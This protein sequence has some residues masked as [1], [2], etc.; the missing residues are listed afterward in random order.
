MEER[1]GVAVE[2]FR[3]TSPRWPPARGELR[4]HGLPL[5]PSPPNSAPL[6]GNS[7]TKMPESFRPCKCELEDGGAKEAWVGRQG[8]PPRFAKGILPVPDSVDR[9][10]L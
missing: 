7:D 9:D 3:G 1:D 2:L 4:F 10:G 5:F 6:L 8:F